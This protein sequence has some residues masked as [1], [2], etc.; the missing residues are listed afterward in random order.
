MDTNS[1]E[2]T[3]NS[4]LNTL[5]CTVAPLGAMSYSLKRIKNL[6]IFK[7]FFFVKSQLSLLGFHNLTNFFPMS[8][9]YRRPSLKESRKQK[10]NEN[11]EN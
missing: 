3:L 6:K 1:L 9:I 7:N 4:I 10:V 5:P 2:K 8:L 11:S